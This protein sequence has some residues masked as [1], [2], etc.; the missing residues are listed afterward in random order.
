MRV[1]IPTMRNSRSREEE[2]ED[3]AGISAYLFV[4]YSLFSFH[5]KDYKL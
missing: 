5:I 1:F 2:I 4:L 3:M